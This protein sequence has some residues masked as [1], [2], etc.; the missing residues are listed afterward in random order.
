MVS[1]GGLQPNKEGE[2]L[3]EKITLES[4]FDGING[5]TDVVQGVK[6]E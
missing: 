4:P 5:P 1:G 2:M 3:E 6:S